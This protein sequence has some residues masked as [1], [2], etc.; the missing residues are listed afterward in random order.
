MLVYFGLFYTT[1]NLDSM[2]LD[3]LWGF[4]LLIE[5]WCYIEQNLGLKFLVNELKLLWGGFYT[6]PALLFLFDFA[7]LGGRKLYRLDNGVKDEA[8]G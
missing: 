6:W 3:G 7:F 5:R 2:K 8:V 4:R 1:K